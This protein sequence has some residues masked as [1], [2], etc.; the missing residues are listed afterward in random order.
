LVIP[1]HSLYA[2]NHQY[3]AAEISQNP[4]KFFPLASIQTT[5]N[6]DA[7]PGLRNL[8]DV[9]D[10][11]TRFAKGR[12]IIPTSDE[13]LVRA[14]YPRVEFD[15]SNVYEPTDHRVKR[16]GPVPP[17]AEMNPIIL[18]S[19]YGI[20]EN[21]TK[22]PGTAKCTS[23]CSLYP[24]GGP[25]P[26]SRMVPST[27]RLHG[28]TINHTPNFQL[29][30]EP[31]SL[32]IE[33]QQR[34]ASLDDANLQIG[35]WH[36][37]Q[38]LYL[39]RLAQI[40]TPSL[41]GL[42]FLPGLVVQAEDWHFVASTRE[43]KSTIV[44]T[45]NTVGSTAELDGAYQVIRAIQYLAWWTETVCWLWFLSTILQIPAEGTEDINA[46]S[47]SD[48]VAPEGVEQGRERDIDDQVSQRH[49]I[50]V[51]ENQ[52]ELA[53]HPRLRSAVPIAT[54][55]LTQTQLQDYRN[56]PPGRQT[57]SQ[58]AKAHTHSDVLAA[59]FSRPQGKPDNI[60]V[61]AGVSSKTPLSL[62]LPLLSRSS[63]YPHF[64]AAPRIPRD[65]NRLPKSREFMGDTLRRGL[66]WAQETDGYIDQ[67]YLLSI[68]TVSGRHCL[69][70]FVVNL[71]RDF[72]INAKAVSKPVEDD[73]HCMKRTQ[74]TQRI[75]VV[76]L[77]QHCYEEV[78]TRR[79]GPDIIP[80]IPP[81]D[82]S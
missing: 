65:V 67:G 27:S 54:I 46:A 49:L 29:R 30:N 72:G 50:T 51:C 10:A 37:A 57:R 79:G 44:W 5:Q 19:Q 71:P 78:V 36:A 12:D 22:Q 45:K 75:L 56:H 55:T 13:E 48:L 11:I 76:E 23:E 20:Q 52:R 58:S 15:A 33:S 64:P 28:T 70:L 38:W 17:F 7:R 59:V 61:E 40:N 24:C 4:I 68:P 8:R 74:N 39:D 80:Q 81:K 73:M 41:Q 82:M 42:P 9:H 2:S 47:A 63:S 77:D 26:L 62:P 1:T 34:D 18:A 21:S 53:R 3:A 14:S 43:G 69:V 6:T 25:S 32:S 35:T 16:Y 60:N 31:I 66:A